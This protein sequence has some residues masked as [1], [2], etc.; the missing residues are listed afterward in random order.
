MKVNKILKIFLVAIIIV[1]IQGVTIAATTGTVNV[2]TVRVRKKPTTDSAIVE[3]VS[4]GDKITIIGEEDNWYKVKVNGIEGYIRSD[5]LTVKG[6]VTTTEKPTDNNDTS[7]ETPN[8]VEKP[9]E[10]NGEVSGEEISSEKDNNNGETS[11]ENPT[12][13]LPTEGNKIQISKQDK[14]I[15][16]IK[17]A[18]LSVGQKLQLSEDVKIKILPLANSSN[19]AKL[20]ANTEVTVLEVINSWCRVETLEGVCGW[21][22]IDQ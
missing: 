22:R 11:N 7:E 20:E 1:S 18:S 5:L 12:E 10:N 13:N 14:T 6:E 19:I 16:V 15:S 17:E 3:L 8:E 9:N 21:V 4:I 2:D